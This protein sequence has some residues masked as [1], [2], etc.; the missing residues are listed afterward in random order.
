MNRKRCAALCAA[1][2]LSV[3][4]AFAQ[5]EADFNVALTED[6]EGAVITRY[7]GKA[8]AM[9]IPA[10]IQGMPVR[11]IGR[12]AFRFNETVTSVVIP[13][14]VTKIGNSAFFSC[15]RL[16]SVTI[17]EGVT[18]I[19]ESAFDR[20]EQLTEAAL[21]KSLKT[22]REKAFSGTAITA[23]TIP[24]GTKAGEYVFMNCN[25]LK[26]VTLPEDMEY[27]PNEMFANCGALTAITLPASIKEIGWRAFATY[28]SSNLFT[29]TIPD[30]VETINFRAISYGGS[31]DA[32]K[33][34]SNLS[35]ASQAALKKRGYKGRF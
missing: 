16:T 31:S 3:S 34:C 14:G 11:E 29:V 9:S 33:G 28:G 1:L 19:C 35:L 24:A 8:A 13:A 32:F 17:P 20:C 27:I 7:T 4:A 25:N 18:E 12:R 5:T 30:S 2:V 21:P 10:T 15:Y 22:L 26:N 23:V 6:G